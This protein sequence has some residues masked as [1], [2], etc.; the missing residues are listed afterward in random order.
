MPDTPGR[1]ERCETCRFWNTESNQIA[2]SETN[3]GGKGTCQRM[4][5]LISDA[6]NR[7]LL[8]EAERDVDSEDSEESA[9]RAWPVTWDDDWCGEWQPGNN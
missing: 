7:A 1:P 2:Q 3:V 9:G 8:R 4:P 5:P 6:Y